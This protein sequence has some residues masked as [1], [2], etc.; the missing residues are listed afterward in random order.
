MAIVKKINV[1]RSY[2]ATL[3]KTCLILRIDSWKAKDYLWHLHADKNH[4]ISAEV[5]LVFG[6]GS[7]NGQITTKTNHYEN[8]K[9]RFAEY[10]IYRIIC[11]SFASSIPRTK[12]SDDIK[13]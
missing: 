3:I 13:I 10:S 12:V 1:T 9:K 4:N 5:S 7:Q 8:P 2:Q 11:R 6:G